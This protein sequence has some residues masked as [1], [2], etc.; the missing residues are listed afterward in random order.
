[1]PSDRIVLGG[2]SQGGGMSI[3]TGLTTTH[4]LAGV[5][6]LAAYLLLS[7]KIKALADEGGNANRETKWFVG[8]GDAD[9]LI[10]YDWG[11]KTA[12]FLR[13]DLGVKDLE[14]KTYHGLGHSADPL[15][16]DHLE[17][18]LHRCLPPLATDPAGPASTKDEL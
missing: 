4:K 15:E 17:A 2:F 1:M 18:F 10:K 7:D 6:A 13:K 8:H 5:F 3:F 16:I 9:P 11:V 14:F 12:E